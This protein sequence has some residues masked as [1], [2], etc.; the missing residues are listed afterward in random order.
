MKLYLNLNQDIQRLCFSR[1]G[2][3][4]RQPIATGWSAV[5][6]ACRS[7]REMILFCARDVFGQVAH[8]LEH[9]RAAWGRMPLLSYYS[10]TVGIIGV[11][12]LGNEPSH[13]QAGE[14]FESE[15]TEELAKTIG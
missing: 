15:I 9:D 12:N 1:N 8:F 4:R 5:G 2:L 6:Q 3:A 7:T 10:S 14:P 13:Y 11:G